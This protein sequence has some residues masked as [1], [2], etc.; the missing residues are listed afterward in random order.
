MS[1]P[2]SWL[3]P[4]IGRAAPHSA[5]QLCIC[6]IS[7]PWAAL[8]RPARS[9]ICWLDDWAK[10][11][12]DIWMAPSWWGIIIVTNMTSTALCSTD[13]IEEEAEVV[14]AT[15]SVPRVVGPPQAARLRLRVNAQDAPQ[16]RLDMRKLLGMKRV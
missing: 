2:M 7:G 11:T 6:S 13:S 1:C 5:S 3:G 15:V 8:I 10:A 9:W 16:I 14:G 4:I 12:S